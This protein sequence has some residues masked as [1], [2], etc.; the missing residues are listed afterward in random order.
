M[1]KKNSALRGGYGSN[2]IDRGLRYGFI[3]PE[4]AD[5]FRLLVSPSKRKNNF[6]SVNS[7]A[8]ANLPEADKAGGEI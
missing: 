3:S 6:I 5:G 8:R 4:R 7:V 2:V 1:D